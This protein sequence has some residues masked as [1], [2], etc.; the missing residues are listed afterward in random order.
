MLPPS[1]EGPDG[2]TQAAL[3]AVFA[4]TAS[5][6]GDGFFRALVE[7]LARALGTHGAWVTE[8]F[9]RERVL[10]A[11]AF[12]LGNEWLEGFEQPVDGTPCKVVIEDRRVVHY[13][14]RV[15]E[16]YPDEPNLRSVQAVSYLGVPLRDL[17]G[18]VLGHLAV[19]DIKPMPAD[20]IKLTLFEIFAGRAAA[21]L[22]RLRAEKEVRAREAQLAGLV[23]SAMDAIVQLDGG[24]R[25]TQ[26][27]AAA[28]RTFEQPSEHAQG[29]P[30]S[31]LVAVE[32]AAK[33]EALC[34]SLGERPPAERSAWVPGGL[35][36]RTAGG[37]TFRA[38][39]TLSLFELDG[40][41]HF[42]L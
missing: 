28:E 31:T 38:E 21:E 33:L 13:P 30:L 6:V 19:M 29:M 35:T 18:T 34:R 37:S 10:R 26:M 36:G 11:R 4:G 9:P 7:N 8:F 40:N 41:Q 39:A 22:R 16:I 12:R 5:E 20:P 42:T 23:N 24:V 15:L 1:S 3:Q 2:S 25:I 17:D 27:N 14:D 32:D